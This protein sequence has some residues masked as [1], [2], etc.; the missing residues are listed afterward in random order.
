ML[1]RVEQSMIALTAQVVG[2]KPYPASLERVRAMGL[3][4]STSASDLATIVESDPAFAA[5]LLRLSNA[6]A[7]GT[8]HRCT[9]IRHAIALLG[10]SR[11]VEL[12]IAVA[13]V[14]LVEKASAESET[15]LAHSLLT[16]TLA[17]EIAP[18][19]GVSPHELYA[20]A[21]LH[22]VGKILFLQSGD[23]RYPELLARFGNEADAIYTHEITRYGFDHALLGAHVLRKWGIFEPLPTLVELHHDV[24]RAE[25]EAPEL[26][27][28]L[29]ALRIANILAHSLGNDDE[30]ECFGR[31]L[32]EPS[33]AST[34]LRG[35]LFIESWP[36]LR[37]L[38]TDH[39]AERAN[40]YQAAHGEE[41]RSASELP[42]QNGVDEPASVDER[43]SDPEP[44]VTRETR[45]EDDEPEA[46]T[47]EADESATEPEEA[48]SANLTDEAHLS[49]SGGRPADDLFADVATAELQVLPE[50][51]SLGELEATESDS[52]A[53]RER[54]DQPAGR[55][56]AEVEP[57][58][59][60]DPGDER[61]VGLLPAEDLVP[62]E[63]AAE[64]QLLDR[65]LAAADPAE[66][67]TWP[68]ADP[69]EPTTSPDANPVEPRKSPD[70]NLTE[71]TSAATPKS[72]PTDATEPAEPPNP[73]R[74][75]ALIGGALP[76][77]MAL[78]WLGLSLARGLSPIPPVVML[79]VTVGVW[80][81]LLF[82]LRR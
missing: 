41:L 35:E 81:G 10:A 54:P 38:A 47:S 2:V 28:R 73:S 49:D 9:S 69:A 18:Q 48:T 82:M 80:F 27:P 51:G 34:G 5:I 25:R 76:P 58:D 72:E 15:L 66:P 71:A 70:A 63:R 36:R 52:L 65:S 6:A 37:A 1:L 8:V 59:E 31:L 61:H 13:S 74:W 79:V 24:A 77:L 57:N 68:D 17:R 45:D 3:D 23:A 44:L 55:G 20:T 56:A 14:Q 32:G 62:A 78:A 46:G 21:I 33:L 42:A 7:L 75:I 40:L 64:S 50:I 39:A 29:A 26:M 11:V 4:E 53:E 67:T 60:G 12:A 22:D 16:A 30:T 19:F 43:S